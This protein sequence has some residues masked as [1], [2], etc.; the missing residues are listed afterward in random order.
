MDTKVNKILKIFLEVFFIVTIV[1]FAWSITP[2][3]FQ[4]DTYYTI[5]IGEV[6][7]NT[8]N[9]ANDLLPWGK[10]LDMKDHFSYHNLPYTY[11]H[12]LYDLM[13]YKVYAA[14]GF[15]GIYGLTCIFTIILGLSIYLV[16]IKLNKNHNISYLITIGSIY[17]LKNFVAARAQ[18]V[19]YILFVLT[20]FFIEMFIRKKN[21]IYPIMLVI[22]SIL[23]ANLHCA[24]W[25]FY[26]V[27]YVPYIVAWLCIEIVT[28]DYQNHF[29]KWNLIT[30]KK[31]MKMNEYNEKIL[32]INTKIKE[33][34]K[35][36]EGRFDRANKIDISKNHNIKW[37][38]LVMIICAFTGLLT[39]IKDVP[40]TY[41]V[42]TMQGTTTQN[43]SEHLP[44]VLVGHANLIVILI[45]I[46]GSLI[47]SRAKIK[48]CDFFMIMGLVGLS[49]IS[50]R[51]ISLL[52]VVG[53]FIVTKMLC[54]T[55]SGIKKK[56]AENE[57]NINELKLVRNVLMIT[58]VFSVSVISYTYYKEKKN[59]PFVDDTEYP[60]KAAEFINNNLIPIIGKENLR[61]YNEYNY[62]S[63]L[64]FNDIPVFIDSRAD[65]YAP[66]FNGTK[67][68]QKKYVGND[69]FQDFIGINNLSKDY[70][71]KFNE[72]K[73]THVI[74]YEDSKLS[75]LLDRDGK[76]SLLYSDD[77]FR[78]YE[79][80][81]VY[82]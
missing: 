22:I 80:E 73:V 45:I 61:L 10:G 28:F 16:N 5:K 55:C 41:L 2:K 49:F 39:P 79:R 36:M 38:I 82:E 25:P 67:N 65:L 20:I 60:V 50:Q 31:K 68:K 72:Y 35:I 19:T 24:V 44:T 8:T 70:E 53:N 71:T 76:Y 52:V 1:I 78:I 51:Q 29:K 66:E 9:G 81:N 47:F 54:N 34:N 56:I 48:L 57:S 15:E 4:N 21:L 46:F 69:I 58:L 23:I 32:E 37:L 59:T 6:I 18:L 17:C 27:L 12:W 77:Y 75:Y 33:H 26:F 7:K 11:P 63:Y 62:G 40:Y 13:T 64:L 43:I 74:T 14:R 42:K 3:T 30:H